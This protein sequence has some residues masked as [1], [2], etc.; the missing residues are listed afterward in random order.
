M[1]PTHAR[2]RPRCY[3]YYISQV[4][5]QG[6]AQRGSIV[7]LPATEI[8]ALVIAALRAARP[9]SADL[10]DR[11]LILNHLNRVTVHEGQI[12]MATNDE[13]QAPIRLP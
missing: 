9:M 7:R 12:E 10:S 4:V 8:E 1:T 11:D 3:R 2:K 13:D 6:N 5:L